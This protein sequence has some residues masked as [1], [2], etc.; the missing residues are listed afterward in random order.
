M[1]KTKKKYGLSAAIA[2]TAL[3]ATALL[4]MRADTYQYII[5]ESPYANTSYPAY[6]AAAPLETASQT[7][8][9]AAVSLEARF[10]TWLASI[11][12][13]LRSDKAWGLKIIV[14]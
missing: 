13:A 1:S 11:A 12:T 6:S 5:R 3:A 4:P 9:S 2:L 14:K 8:K 7:A 10:R